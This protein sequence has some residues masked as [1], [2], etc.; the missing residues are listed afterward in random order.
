LAAFS[1]FCEAKIKRFDLRFYAQ[2]E[3]R[4][5]SKFSA[6][7][8]RVNLDI[9]KY[10]K[11]AETQKKA[12]DA[13]K[14][15]AS[16]RAESGLNPRARHDQKI[17]LVIWFLKNFGF[18]TEPLLSFLTSDKTNKLMAS[19]IKKKLVSFDLCWLNTG[20][21]GRL[22]KVYKL[23]TSGY[24][25]FDYDGNENSL[26]N[27][28]NKVR[29]LNQKNFKNDLV[30]QYYAIEQFLTFKDPSRFHLITAFTQDTGVKN[31]KVADFELIDPDDEDAK[32]HF[33]IE[34]SPKS[35]MELDEFVQ[36]ID[37]L[38]SEERFQADG[39]LF[40]REVNIYVA[41][42]SAAARYANAFSH[43]TRYNLIEI[44]KETHRR[45][46]KGTKPIF[47][48]T[49]EQV[50]IHQIPTWLNPATRGLGKITP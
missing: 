24:E 42:E 36:R 33:E 45:H 27:Y 15:S 5:R 11:T 8:L 40:P 21:V 6:E 2:C 18:S 29:R 25:S 16:R 32:T 34:T 38:F 22:S 14:I 46:K 26:K 39:V 3:A 10:M 23:T 9:I 50:C 49:S 28:F 1:R 7:L 12:L 30:S 31:K 48:A 47:D 19:L 20:T 35:G 13:A 37:W 41:G 4:R 43:G 17:M 44:D